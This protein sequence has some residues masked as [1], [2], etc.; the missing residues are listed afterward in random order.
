MAKAFTIPKEPAFSTRVGPRAGYGSDA[1]TKKIF[2][3]QTPR[4]FAGG[5]YLDS[6]NFQRS[7][8]TDR[9]MGSQMESAAR[10]AKSVMSP[11]QKIGIATQN[12]NHGALDL[13]VAGL[14][15]FA[16]HK[17]GG[18]MESKRMVQKEVAFMEKKGAPKSMIKHEKSEAKGYASG[19]SVGFKQ[20]F[21]EARNNGDDTFTWNGKKY[22]T[23]LAKPAAKPKGL[24]ESGK[25]A[26]DLYE[27]YAN[28]A[29]VTRE[30]AKSSYDPDQ[31]NA[32]ADEFES[33]ARQYG[34]GYA[35]AAGFKR[36]GS[37]G[38]YAK[39]G[40]IRSEKEIQDDQDS[41]G[42]RHVFAKGGG[43][44]G[45]TGYQ[46]RGIMENRS[47]SGDSRAGENKKI[48]KR[49]LTEGRVVKMATGGSVKM[50]RGGGCESRGKTRGKYI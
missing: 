25:Q 16:G 18:I 42:A 45:N 48:Q 3:P 5:G 19:G 12:I 34:Q 17:K 37:I 2:G 50:A 33:K 27:N 20:A 35:N 6:P 26:K 9:K 22:T 8:G 14:N 44:R 40:N 11:K 4:K 41:M 29:K 28:A 1:M 36:G 43:I 39:G 38:G 13:P 32:A 7:I 46:G 23:E 49:G 15:K 24:S 47:A 30:Q 21:R 10:K 31:L